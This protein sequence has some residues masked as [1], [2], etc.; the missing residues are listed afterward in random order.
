MLFY[1]FKV[2]FKVILF[3]ALLAI[4]LSCIPTAKKG[5]ESISRVLTRGTDRERDGGR[6]Y[7]RDR[8]LSH[9]CERE[10]D[11]S[12]EVSINNLKFIDSGNV[13]GLSFRGSL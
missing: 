13:G 11:Y 7:D 9:R 3:S 4:T 6:S 5:R 10:D 12:D 8:R 2:L 1:Q